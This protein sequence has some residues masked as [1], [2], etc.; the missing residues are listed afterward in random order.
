MAFRIAAYVS[1]HWLPAASKA[2]FQ[3]L[4]RLSWTGSGPQ[5]SCKRFPAY[6]MF[7]ILLFQAFVA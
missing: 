6:I 2:R 5:G 7:A 4:V 3:V 1:R